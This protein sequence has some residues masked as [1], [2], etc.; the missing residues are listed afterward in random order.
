M[1]IFRL[2]IRSYVLGLPTGMIC[3]QYHVVQQEQMTSVIEYQ[4]WVHIQV[5][6]N[7]I[8]SSTSKHFKNSFRAGHFQ[9]KI[10]LILYTTQNLCSSA[11]AMLI[12]EQYN[13]ES[14]YAQDSQ[15][16]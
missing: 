9:A 6:I 8:Y 11:K 15:Y 12:H 2:L 7:L 13:L 5:G 16:I 3:I 4:F 14:G 1:H 10:T